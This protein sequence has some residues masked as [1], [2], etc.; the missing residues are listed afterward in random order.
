ME[1]ITF[2]QVYCDMETDGGGWTVFQRRM[3]GSVDFYRTWSDYELGFGDLAE[4][5]WLGLRN[6]HRLT[7]TNSAESHQLRVELSDFAN[8]K[9]YTK[10]SSFSV[11]NSASKYVLNVGGYSGN[12]GDSLS[13]HNGMKFTTKDQD[14]DKYGSN[15]AILFTGAWWYNGCHQSNLNGQYL[16]NS[17]DHKGIQWFSTWKLDTL[18]YTEMKM[19]QN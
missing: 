18:K 2:L 12:A 9:R 15:C 8:T 5:F 14:N 1:F 3:D 6:I 11:G 19:R 4:E 7:T 13:Y 16:V 10:F 17:K